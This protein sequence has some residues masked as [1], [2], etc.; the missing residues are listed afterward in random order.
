MMK[1]SVSVDMNENLL[2]FTDHLVSISEFSKGKTL[3]IFEDVRNNNTDD[4][5][6]RVN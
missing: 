2:K 3:K 6:R 1:V 4:S 5:D